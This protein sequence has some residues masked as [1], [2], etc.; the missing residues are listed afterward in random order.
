MRLTDQQRQT[1]VQTVR[2]IM[3]EPAR[4]S[5]FGS[6]VDDSL[7]GGDVDLL[8]EIPQ[9]VPLSLEITLNAHLE[10]RLG[11]SVDIITATPD[12]CKK[13]FVQI[14]KKTGIRL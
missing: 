5:L 9:Q 4:V 12:Q 1:I 2:E 13:P 8:V 10:E 11:E 6:R 7:T 14:A 3:G